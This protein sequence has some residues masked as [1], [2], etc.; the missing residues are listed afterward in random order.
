MGIFQSL[1]IAI[2][3]GSIVIPEILIINSRNLI[4]ITENSFFLISV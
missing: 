4:N 1:I 3:S 2:F